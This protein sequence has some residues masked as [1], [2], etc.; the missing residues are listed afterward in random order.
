ML[1][2][3]EDAATDAL[4]RLQAAGQ[5][6][7][8]DGSR[9]LGAFRAAGLIVPVWEVPPERGAPDFADAVASMASKL[10]DA[11]AATAPLSPD[12]RR[13]KAGLVNRQVTLR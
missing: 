10:D 4:A 7:L 8:S 13:A 2:Y 12:E 1:S 5:V 11:A 6:A 9:L 3:D